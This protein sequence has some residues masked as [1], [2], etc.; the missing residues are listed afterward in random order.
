LSIVICISI[1]ET[2]AHHSATDD[3]PL[4]ILHGKFERKNKEKKLL[5]TDGTQLDIY[6][7]SLSLGTPT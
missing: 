1:P 2:S 6:L 3:L 7:W 4:V 5:P